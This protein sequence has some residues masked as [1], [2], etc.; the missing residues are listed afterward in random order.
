MAQA[1][2][3]LRPDRRWLVT[4]RRV[5]TTFKGGE[6]PKEGNRCVTQ[7]SHVT[8]SVSVCA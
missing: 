3:H 8:L 2:A 4:L 5:F 6:G 1:R 7:K